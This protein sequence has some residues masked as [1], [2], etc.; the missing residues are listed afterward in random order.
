MPSNNRYDLQNNSEIEAIESFKLLISN[1]KS[2][3][4]KTW[5]CPWQKR[6]SHKSLIPF[7]FEESNEF[8]D[9]FV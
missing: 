1:I 6:Q 4:D 7:L 2:L 5:G 3:K 9:F 8:I